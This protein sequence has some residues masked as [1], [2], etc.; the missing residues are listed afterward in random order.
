MFSLVV[1]TTS[2]QPGRCVS[3]GPP[4]GTSSIGKD[5]HGVCT[6]M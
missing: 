3:V 6:R 1:F 4:D 2:Q 5:D